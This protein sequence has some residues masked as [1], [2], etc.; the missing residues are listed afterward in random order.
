MNEGVGGLAGLVF[1]DLIGSIFWFPM[2]WYTKGLVKLVGWCV[3]ALEYRKKQYAFGVW[4]RNFFVPMY[5]QWD[6]TGRIISMFMRTVVII[7]RGIGLALEALI[8]VFLCVCW[9][10]LPPL[11]AVLLL[12]NLFSG[13]LA[14][15]PKPF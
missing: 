10:I 11:A 13:T 3:K 9:I 8:Y 14:R 5:G 15:I 1:V 7:G 4:I 2:W 12:Q 6:W